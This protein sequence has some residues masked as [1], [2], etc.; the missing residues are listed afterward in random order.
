MDESSE[1]RNREFLFWIAFWLQILV[2][3]FLVAV[4]FFFASAARGRGDYAVGLALSLSAIAL[5]FFFLKRSLD[6]DHRLWGGFLF[7]ET[8]GEL[9]VAIPLSTVIGLLGLFLAHAAES[10]SLYAAGMGLFA[11]SALAVFLNIKRTY[12]RIEE[13]RH[14]EIGRRRRRAP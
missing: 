4:G 11:A 10:G 9:A 3:V 1:D 12:D 14:Q 7:A 13:S 5:F 8:M 2:L 6:G